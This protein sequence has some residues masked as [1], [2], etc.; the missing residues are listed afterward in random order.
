M[1]I[2]ITILISAI[3]HLKVL[4]SPNGAPLEACESMLPNHAPFEPLFGEPPVDIIVEGW[5]F[6]PNDK[7]S[8]TIQANESNF[9]FRG[10]LVQARP[11]SEDTPIG[12]FKSSSE[13][14]SLNCFSMIQSAATHTNA[15]PKSKVVLE[16]E[17]PDITDPIAFEL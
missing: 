11:L 12:R 14:N 3:L 7:I 8:I 6:F 17:A 10:F 1:W 9:Q 5:N 4:A 13:V 2:K 15:M 16:W